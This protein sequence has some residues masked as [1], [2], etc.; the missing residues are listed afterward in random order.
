[1]SICKIGETKIINGK[2]YRK[3]RT[4]DVA[5]C[6]YC[7]FMIEDHC[8]LFALGMKLPGKSIEEGGRE[9][10]GTIWILAEDHPEA[11]LVVADPSGSNSDKMHE[12]VWNNPTLQRLTLARDEL[13]EQ[14]RFEAA[15]A[16]M[17][18]M[19]GQWEPNWERESLA[20]LAVGYADALIAEL[21]RTGEGK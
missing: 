14:R 16:A 20:N 7:S 8:E 3:E 10:A 19:L 13:R 12:P 15:V 21:D 5:C 18:G 1:M 17:Q 2:R 9:C 11:R 4:T 6:E